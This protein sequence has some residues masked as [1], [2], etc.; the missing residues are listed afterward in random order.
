MESHASRILLANLML[1]SFLTGTASRIFAISLPT[2]AEN[3]RTDMAGISWALI[4]FQLSAISL[5]LVFGKLGD[6]YG[7]QTVFGIGLLVFTASSFLCGLSQ[8]I[9]QLIFYRLLQG[10]GGAM[11]QAQGRALVMESAPQGSV[12]KAQGFLTT[13]HHTGFLLGPSLGGFIIDYIHW[14]GIFFSLVP[15]GTAGALITWLTRKRS[16]VPVA[17]TG[18][19]TRSSIDYL[20]AALLVAT[21]LAL[22]AILDR[23]IMEVM[24]PGWR[25]VLILAFVGFT[26]V[27]LIREGTA[28]S[29]IL[30]LS[31]FKIRMFAIST[32]CL[33]LVTIIYALTVFLLPFYLQ[34][35]L[36]L[37]PSFMGILF[38]AAPVFTIT[39]SP[40]GGYIFDKV[41]SRL[42]AT[43]GMVLFGVASFLGTILRTDSHWLLPTFMI[44]LGGLASA[45]FFPP[46][47]TAMIG[48]V[49]AEHR[50][51]ATGSIYTMFGL[52]NIFGITLGS[53]L[54]TAAFRFHT[55]LSTA[56]PSTADP[57]TF[58]A[59]LN[60]TFLVVVGIA[61]GGV[62][63]SLMRGT[64]GED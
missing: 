15:I 30:N 46:N 28:S 38:M 61:L 17:P 6:L 24:N 43:T 37:S 1:G 8:N 12:G 5:S 23:R 22:I 26:V 2:V 7:R 3:L 32:V 14:R 64:K 18:I 49:P 39:L 52:G 55:G 20:G 27:F 56:T 36:H 42:P 58:I 51:V 10:V 57:T 35:V 48:S 29:P 40:V 53:F 54:M 45:L 31:L 33:L 21:A 59:A 11:I 13:A 50:G 62:I 16:P 60:A 34:D 63:L 25:T 41:G 44:A 19:A 47:H 4:S 9:F